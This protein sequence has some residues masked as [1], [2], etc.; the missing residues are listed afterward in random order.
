MT[1]YTDAPARAVA[2]WQHELP[3]LASENMLLIGRLKRAAALIARELDKVYGEY[4]LSEGAFDVLATLRRSGAP[5][6]LTPTELFSSLMVTSGTMTTR[7]KNMEN[8]G[9]IERL[10]NPDDARSLLVRLTGK[11][12]DLIE[13]A[14]FPHVENEK[15]LME[16]LDA[17]TRRQLEEGLA[18]WLRGLEGEG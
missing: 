10:P 13:Q 9:L 15:R 7:L 4:G 12:R 16:K 5:Y 1:E 2:Q 8:Q 14:V 18:A 6:T 11:G 17:E 3:E